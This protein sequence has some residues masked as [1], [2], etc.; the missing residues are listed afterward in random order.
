[1]EI[2]LRIY[3]APTFYQ[4][5]SD[6]CFWFELTSLL[7]NIFMHTLIEIQQHFKIYFHFGL[8]FISALRSLR[9][10]RFTRQIIILKIFLCALIFGTRELFNLFII[11][12][13]FMIF[14]GEFI[15]LIEEWINISLIQTVTGKDNASDKFILA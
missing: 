10:L 5:Y 8:S 1:M 14:F 4:L 13:N 12:I 9:I 7:S 11:L 15:Y 2:C 3:L 6:V